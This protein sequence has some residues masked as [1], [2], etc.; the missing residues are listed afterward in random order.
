LLE[1]KLQ[2]ILL[3][4][5]AN[6]V[7][8]FDLNEIIIYLFGES[9]RKVETIIVSANNRF[10][11]DYQYRM[12]QSFY[13]EDVN[14]E[15]TENKKQIKN[16]VNF[17]ANRVIREQQT[18]SMIS[19]DKPPLKT[20]MKSV[21]FFV[22]SEFGFGKTSLLLNLF[23]KLEPHNL[24]GI[25]LPVAQFEADS[26]NNEYSLCKNI[27]SILLDKTINGKQLYEK[28]LI[29]SFQLMV[30]NRR[31]L[32]F[33]VDGLDETRHSYSENGLKRIF[34]CFR[35]F[36]PACIFTTRK[37][38]WDERCGNFDVA[39]GK[40]K[41][42]K[43]VLLLKE[44]NSSDIS[45]YLDL[46]KNNIRTANKKKKIDTFNDL[47]RNNRYEEY[48]GDI[49]KRPL[50]LKML[51]DDIIDG[52]IQ[53]R[54][55]SQLYKKYL[56]NKFILDRSNSVSKSVERRPLHLEGDINSVLPAI[57]SILEK[58]A[59]DMLINDDGNNIIFLSYIHESKIEE[60]I[61]KNNLKLIS[62]VE[63]LLNSVLV[64]FDKRS[65]SDFR[66]KFSHKS[67]QEYFT[68]RFL[69]NLLCNSAGTR[70][71]YDL[72]YFNFSKGVSEFLLGLISEIKNDE[73][74]SLELN[75]CLSI[76]SGLF[77]ESKN[78]S[79]IINTVY[80]RINS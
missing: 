54:S 70:R 6:K 68:A 80:P 29:K 12:D 2:K 52:E 64:P 40:R 65:F 38:L 77:K 8:L 72:F 25:Y 56:I 47:V 7:Y 1:N 33:L 41:K 34:D 55:L 43:D 31:D 24:I 67:F 5:K 27:L 22:V 44:W 4:K 74:H 62:T 19:T 63:I 50:F 10:K 14:F 17:I 73:R 59:G 58:I 11:E 37:E 75:M 69:F 26:Y 76:A 23:D 39:I 15:L 60:A 16:P 42:F 32:V 3:Q 21:W 79:A 9:S 53:K 48:Y 35:N 66:V 28:F 20:N 61:Q 78:D 13:K 49:P 51:I 71:D 30:R 57:F 45:D 18:V 36:K 46:F